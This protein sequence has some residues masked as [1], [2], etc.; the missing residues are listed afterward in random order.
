MSDSLVLTL[1]LAVTFTLAGTVKGV[2][3][4]G[5]P[6]VAM[7]LL[8]TLMSPSIAAALLVIPS[9]VTN[10]WQLLRGPHLHTVV[11]RLWPMMLAIM[12][13][14]LA[15]AALLTKVDARWSGFALGGVL[16]AYVLHGLLAPAL[17][18]P[19]WVERRFSPAVGVVT[20]IVTGATGV[21]VIPVVPWLQSL[22]MEREVLV[23]AFGLSFTVSTFALA[24]GL[25]MQGAFALS[26]LGLSTLSVLPALAGMWLGQKI[27]ARISPR[28]FR[29]CLLMFLLLLG[30]QLLLRPVLSSWG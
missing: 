15:G 19:G 24:M 23:Q 2:T 14:T 5:L 8:G 28:R 27:R 16:V 10:V 11:Q 6:T 18:V 29:Q 30:L 17:Q 4:M 20:G 21:S 1:L 26:T 12:V 3:G 25:W 22:D 9:L 7:A 13:S